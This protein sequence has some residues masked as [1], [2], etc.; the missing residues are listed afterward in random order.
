M[1]FSNEE[2]EEKLK[3]AV[4]NVTPDI[5]ES[6]MSNCD[7]RKGAVIQMDKKTSKKSL[8]LKLAAVAAS[9]VM[10][11]GVVLGFNT[12][13]SGDIVD[14]IVSLDVNPS[15]EI[16]VNKD[17]RIVEIVPLNNDAIIIIDKMDFKGAT[18]D[19][20]VNAIIGSMLKH[21]YISEI[22]NSILLTVN[23][24]DSV[25][26]D[27][28]QKK[29]SG[30]I[31]KI[32]KSNS[33]DGAILAQTSHTDAKIEKLA[34]D[35]NISAGK[36]RL[37][38]EI[39]SQDKTHNF[40]QLAKLNVNELN[41]LAKSKNLVLKNTNSTGDV[42]EKAYIGSE[43]ATAIALKHANV[44]NA[45]GILTE[46]DCD[47]GKIIYEVEFNVRNIEYDYD[48]DAV[49]GSILLLTTRIIA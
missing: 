15:V 11:F 12:F 44:A 29:L 46:F 37:I 36:V 41:L 6:I 18:L 7:N 45:T 22:Q 48:I 42:S 23:N 34:H 40:S 32:L 39:L 2:I 4:S 26:G 16:K 43:N 20:A 24:N 30:E 8:V 14:S 19:V 27:A 13:F 10:L 17:E 3:N 47:D 1:N 25:K 28:L 35:N 21:G 33:I 49:T 38:N 31:D 9:V 5:L